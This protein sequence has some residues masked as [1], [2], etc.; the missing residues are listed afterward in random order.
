VLDDKTRASIALLLLGMWKFTVDWAP[1]LNDFHW[2]MARVAVCVTSIVAPE[3]VPQVFTDTL[4]GWV[5][6]KLVC[7]SGKRRSAAATAPQGKTEANASTSG[8]TAEG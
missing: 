2:V 1:T 3:L 8:L 5:G 6:V 4:P 7:C